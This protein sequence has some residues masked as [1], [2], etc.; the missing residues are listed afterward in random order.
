MLF[1]GSNGDN[2]LLV[3]R[4]CTVVKQCGGDVKMKKM[5]KIGKQDKNR[6]LNLKKES[7]DEKCERLHH[8][9]KYSIEIINRRILNQFFS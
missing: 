9:N 4:R 3:L 5:K 7:Y 8:M 1:C 6:I 2:E